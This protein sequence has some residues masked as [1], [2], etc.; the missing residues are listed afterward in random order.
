MG[1]LLSAYSFEVTEMNKKRSAKL[2]LNQALPSDD[3]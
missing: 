2:K 1:S 3:K